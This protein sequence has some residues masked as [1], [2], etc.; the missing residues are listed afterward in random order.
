MQGFYKYYYYIES[1][2]DIINQLK[3][4]RELI[5]FLCN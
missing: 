3:Y 4:I 1:T 5:K 2:Y